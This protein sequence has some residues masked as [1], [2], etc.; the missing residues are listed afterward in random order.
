M[1]WVNF[2]EDAIDGKTMS[3]QRGHPKPFQGGSIGFETE[4]MSIISPSRETCLKQTNKQ[5]NISKGLW[6][7]INLSS[8]NKEASWNI[9]NK[10]SPLGLTITITNTKYFLCVRH[11]GKSFSWVISLKTQTI[12]SI[13]LYRWGAWGTDR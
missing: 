8:Y 5:T 11:H 9:I 6:V 4:R 3:A 12:L 7:A 1:L 10:N 2:F 13:I